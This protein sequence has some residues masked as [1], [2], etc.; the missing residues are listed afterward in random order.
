M[1]HDQCPSCSAPTLTCL[2]GAEILLV[3]NITMAAIANLTSQLAPIAKAAA[4]RIVGRWPSPDSGPSVEVVAYEAAGD[5]AAAAAQPF[6]DVDDISFR[7]VVLTEL[8]M[9]LAGYG[10]CLDDDHLPTF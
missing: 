6:L 3:Q 5:V 7:G 8:K 1:N 10:P 4:E 9:C 2:D